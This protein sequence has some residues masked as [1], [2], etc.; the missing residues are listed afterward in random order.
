MNICGIVCE[1]NPFHNGHRRL[2]DASRAAFGADSAVVCVMSGDFVQ[3]GEAAAFLKHDRARAAV[4]GGADLVL[5]LPLP[6]CM[7]RAETFARGAVGV[8]GACGVV[9]HLCFGSES[10]DL[11][12]LRA[13]ARTLLRPE[14]DGLIRAGLEEGIGYAAARQRALET[15]TGGPAAAL[16]QPND[17]LAVEYLKALETLGIQMTPFAVRRFG[18]GHDAAEEAALPSAAFLRERIRSGGDIGAWMPRAAYE[19]LMRGCGP[20]DADA[21]ETAILSRLR[22]APEAAF[23]DAPD[24]SEGLDKRVYAAAR[25]EPTLDA[26][27]DAASTK[28]YPRARVRR[29]ALSAALGLRASDS[30]GLPPYLRCLAANARGL[31]LL[32]LMEDRAALPVLTKSAHVRR[33]GETAQ[34]VFSLGAAAADLCALGLRDPEARRGDRDWR[35]GP[36]LSDGEAS[37]CNRDANVL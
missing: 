4:A 27:A 7:A 28:R 9:T 29:I 35:C 2:I 30:V 34:R 21:I 3:R 1:Y 33:L 10:G 24:V 12:T 18:A 5:E 17:I 37:V 13:T 15:L 11:A 36:A 16:T 25:T 22:F 23:A 6:W 19:A 14:M 8:L 26:L 32:R 20:T 31:K